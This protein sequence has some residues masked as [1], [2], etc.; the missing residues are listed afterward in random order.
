[1]SPNGTIEVIPVL[2]I[3]EVTPGANL[4]R[5]IVEAATSQGAGLVDG[6]VV[7]VTQKIVSKAEGRLV[8]VDGP[9]ALEGV[10]KQQ[11]RRILRKRAELTISETHHGFVCAN[12]GVDQSDIPEGW[13]SILP[14]DPDASA[15]RIRAEI[16]EVSGA[17]VGVI[18][19]D[20]FGRPWRRGQTDVAL[21]VAGIPAVLDLR[22]TR[23]RFGRTL[24]ATEIAVADEIAGAAELAM[25]KSRGVPAAI[26]RGLSLPE[27]E[28]KGSDLIRHF[29]EDLF[30]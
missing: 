16:A 18:V 30:R 26:V 11:S 12:A 24:H 13:A 20:T 5:L 28:G 27:Q 21:G 7:V 17:I 15:R 22:G 10:V 2:G 25:G 6:D 14:K 3:G 9:K 19:S 29:T 4:G 1:V 23:D 8:A